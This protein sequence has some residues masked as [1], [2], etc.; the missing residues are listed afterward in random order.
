MFTNAPSLR[1]VALASM[2]IL[3][4]CSKKDDGGSTPA[5]TYAT[6]WTADGKNYS[7]TGTGTLNG[8]TLLITAVQSSSSTENYS[9]GL[10][11]PATVGTYNLA[12]T[13][14]SATYI[15]TTGGT[16][17]SYAASP[18]LSGTSGTVTVSTLSATEIIGTFSFTASTLPGSGTTATKAV[19]NGKFSIKR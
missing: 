15:A 10:T 4:A 6:T 2:V 17:T 13:T 14:S 9:I 5:T 1:A 12:N 19:S 16:T 3:G 7:G 11:V 18:A 8:N